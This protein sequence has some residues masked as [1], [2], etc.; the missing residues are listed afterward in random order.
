MSYDAV[1]MG[2]PLLTLAGRPPL[3]RIGAGIVNNLGLGEWVARSEEE[4]VE[5][6][7]G[8]GADLK[9]LVE[10]RK[11]MRER[12]AGSAWRDEAGYARDV[13]RAYREMWRRWC[14]G[15]AAAAFDVA[16]GSAGN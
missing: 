14:A 6:A 4:Y 5:K 7:V 9:G 16:P 8:F 1:C 3:G 12:V 13:E 11:W 10:L 15:E 2:V